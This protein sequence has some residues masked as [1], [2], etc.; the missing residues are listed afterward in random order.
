MV[1]GALAGA[2]ALVML[3]GGVAGGGG[4]GPADAYWLRAEARFAPP[5]AF[6]PS[7]AITYDM[8]LVPAA[9]WIQ[10]EQR[11]DPAGTRVSA[12]VKGLQAGH[13]YGVHVHTKPCGYT[14]E[15]AGPHYQN[16][17]SPKADPANEVWL[18][19]T[20]DKKGAAHA[21]AR[22]RWGFRAG[23]AASV[24]IHRDPGGAGERVACFTVPFGQ[25][26]WG[27]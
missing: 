10:V 21:S 16:V 23:E 2:A 22:H 4:S 13:A 27:S 14:G 12:R 1:A 25:V 24:V 17:A 15:A 7:P 3:T 9:A 8:D 11:T 18:D 26:V 19:F 6:V 20:T 5:T